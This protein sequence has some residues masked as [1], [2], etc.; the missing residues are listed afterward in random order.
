LVI[1]RLPA[2]GRRTTLTHAALASLVHRRAPQLAHF[3]IGDAD[4]TVALT[5]SATTNSDSGAAC[6]TA[7]R[8]LPSGRALSREDLRPAAC[9]HDP[10]ASLA[11]DATNGVLRS[12]QA[13]AAG[14]YLGRVAVLP[15]AFVD[16]GDEL[17]L[18]VAVGPVQIERTVTALQ[19][20]S[21]GD[22]VFVR[23]GDG[24]VFRAPPLTGS[25]P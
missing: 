23:D 16:T 13:I 19:P 25:A 24:H 5:H 9:T 8:D 6:Y 20:A 3:D 7:A 21:S 11:Y 1:A 10:S 12:A 4:A 14:A 22:A 17:S 2:G 18:V 15:A